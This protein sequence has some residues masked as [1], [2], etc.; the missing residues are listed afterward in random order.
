MKP[1]NWPPT[2]DAPVTGNCTLQQSLSFIGLDEAT[3][4]LVGT[5][6]L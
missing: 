3:Y 4:L 5:N 6:R 2:R 1:G